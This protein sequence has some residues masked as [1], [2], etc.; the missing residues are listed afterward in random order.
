[1]KRKAA[2]HVH[3]RAIFAIIVTLIL[4]RTTAE[5]EQGTAPGSAGLV[6]VASWTPLAELA[7]SQNENA[8]QFGQS[9][10]VSGNV[11]VVGSTGDSNFTGAAYVF[12]K[13]SGVLAK[14]PQ[15]ARLTAS[16]RRPGSLFG[17]SVA[18]SG[19][20]IVVGAAGASGSPGK[21]Y[22]FVEPRTG[23]RDM[24]ETAQLTASD[25]QT[26]DGFGLSVAISGS[27]VVAGASAHSVGSNSDEGVA[28]VFVQPS[29]GWVNMTQTAELTASDGT[30]NSR[31]GY[32][33][34]I[35]A[36]TVV[37]GALGSGAVYVFVEPSSGWANT[38]ETAK[39][40]D[41]KDTGV[42]YSVT[43]AGNTIA[44]GSPSGGPRQAGAVHVYVRQ[45]GTWKTT[46]KNATLRPSD[47]LTGDQF[48]FSVATT[49]NTVLAGAPNAPCG[50]SNCRRAGPGVV[51]A[52]ERPATGWV[53]MTEIQKLTASDGMPKGSFGESV[54]ASGPAV[55]IGAIGTNTA[56]AYLYAAN[57]AF[58]AFSM[59][60]ST[61]TFASGVNNQGQIVGSSD[62]G[63]F[64]DTNGVFTTIAYPGAIVTFP[65]AISD[66]GEV[67]GWYEDAS[68]IG[69]G[70][71]ELNG[72]YTSLDYPGSAY[73]YL[74]GVN[75]LGNVVGNFCC[76][77]S[78]QT[79]G[80]VYSSGVFSPIN[81]PGSQSTGVFTINNNGVI[82]GNYCIAPCGGISGF[83][84]DNNVFT[85]ID[86][87]GATFTSIQSIN[88]NG[89]LAGNWSTNTPGQG[90]AFVF[91]NQSHHFV[92]FSLGGP[93]DTS[94]NGI[95]VSGETVGNFCPNNNLP[96]YG[97]Y[98]YLPGH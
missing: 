17:I 53:N 19:N 25:G 61:S 10:S 35:S 21:A 27:T 43:I 67:V 50:G 86:Y 46:S 54:A 38:T 76:V 85:T 7:A 97:F 69:H 90:A 37:A 26:N 77:G 33:A 74:Y 87:P 20:T 28:Y 92:S 40:T 81:V 60:G 66:I 68:G 18:I 72:V 23:W 84:D 95:S 78:G 34:S 75:N 42:G 6:S 80:F 71:T 88:D 93:D 65:Q 94:A 70:F 2:L 64:L 48:G 82:A 9:V 3:G 49:G 16:D 11:A 52:F 96:C 98:G 5:G 14:V 57:S 44:S 32:S 47:D 89:D 36:D 56:Y 30:S 58:T 59:P 4:F 91:W 73:T 13:S 24:T 79:Q 62:L 15:T 1:M 8:S 41:P 39:L 63:G 45:V 12:V 31:L 55:V 51:Y 29:G 22:I 83:V